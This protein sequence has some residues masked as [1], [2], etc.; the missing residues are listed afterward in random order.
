MIAAILLV[1]LFQCSIQFA[2]RQGLRFVFTLLSLF[3]LSSA[4]FA[5]VSPLCPKPIL[6]DNQLKLSTDPSILHESMQKANQEA[7][8]LDWVR[9]PESASACHGYYQEPGNPFSEKDKPLRASN[10]YLSAETVTS[11]EDQTLHLKGNVEAY[12]GSSRISCDNM[13]YNQTTGT[14]I[15][16]G[17]INIR[18]Q[19][20]L[21][22]AADGQ[23]TDHFQTLRLNHTQF[24]MHGRGVRGEAETLNMTT[25][26]NQEKMS[27]VRALVSSC[28][29][30]ENNWTLNAKEI[31]LNNQTGWG[32]AYHAV[33]RIEDVPVFYFPYLNFPINNERKTGFLFPSLSIS[34]DNLDYAQPY[35]INIAPQFDMTY[36]PRLQ[37]DHA[38]GHSLEA[39]YKTRW[40]DWQVNGQY[41][42]DDKNIGDND[43]TTIKNRT[44]E[45]WAYSIKERGQINPYWRTHL[46]Y[47]NVSDNDYFQDWG[48]QGLDIAKTLNIRRE[49][50]VGFYGFNWQVDT[51]VIDY[52]TLEVNPDP[53][54]LYRQLPR[55]DFRYLKIANPF[56]LTPTFYSQYV[57]FQHEHNKVEAQRFYIEPGLRYQAS[58]V[59]GK[60]TGHIEWKHLN[61]LL[62]ENHDLGVNDIT[63]SPYE[64][65]GSQSLNIPSATLDGQLT[66]EKTGNR[67]VQTLTPRLFYY[68]AKYED[69]DKLPSFDTSQ[70]TFSYA[71]LFRGERFNSVDRIGDANQLTYALSTELFDQHSGR[72]FMDAGIGQIF[73]AKD[74][75][76][77]L[78]PIFRKQTP[79]TDSM[80]AGE[81]RYWK[82]RNAQV[83]RYFFNERSD[84]A[85]QMNLYPT[86][87]QRIAL[88]T[89]YDTYTGEFQEGG[90][91]YQFRLANWQLFN[92]GY[93][94]V[95]NVPYRYALP[96][97]NYRYLADDIQEV[98]FSSIWPFTTR[99]SGILRYQYDF[100][101]AEVSDQILGV[102]YENCCLTIMTAFQRERK[103]LDVYEWA[104]LDFNARYRN[105]F[106]LE[107]TLKGLGT[108]NSTISKLLNEKF[109]G[110]EKHN[111]Y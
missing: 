49:A 88:D 110:F 81:K 70:Y 93:R 104:S 64:T 17:H 28:P 51:Q 26:N 42:P 83:N 102:A 34:S 1:I 91:S 41:V 29:P 57:N 53:R 31:D 76:V 9:D 40:G 18:E 33:L 77:A 74:R 11:E 62:N 90:A 72:P 105:H 52:Q 56:T 61:M 59:F 55:M 106:M 10:T 13:T 94:Y 86:E 68:Y 19:G 24:L 21:I 63:Q 16:D 66:F 95:R 32:S 8:A 111:A 84:V 50:F 82:A 92:V 36:T 109:P 39:R 71:Q 100:N 7:N 75:Q 37:T 54:S 12:R 6:N 80:S 79:I 3:S 78:D 47:Q 87:H 99:W 69:Q 15:L 98:D 4:L 30:G 38:L 27:L 44:G 60:F 2:M 96:D 43:N 89:L 14:G 20:F 73:Y 25:M 23:L 5:E 45:R 58:S 22:K 97:G 65:D 35:Y 108:L 85:A 103:T 107:F 101:R 48:T 67:F 46:N